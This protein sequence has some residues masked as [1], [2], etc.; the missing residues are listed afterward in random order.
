MEPLPILRPNIPIF[1]FKVHD[2]E[3]NCALQKKLLRSESTVVQGR[4]KGRIANN[5]E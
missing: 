2:G 4:R 5:L 1:R 3:E